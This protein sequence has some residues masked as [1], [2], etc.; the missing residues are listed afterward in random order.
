M[1][2]DKK[3]DNGLHCQI[4]DIISLL[5]LF[6]DEEMEYLWQEASVVVAKSQSHSVAHAQLVNS[7][8]LKTPDP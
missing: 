8:G 7:K 5:N 6:L 4:Q 1:N 3:K 2:G